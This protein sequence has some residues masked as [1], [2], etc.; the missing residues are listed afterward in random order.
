MEVK[1]ATK[2]EKSFQVGLGLPFLLIVLVLVVLVRLLLVLLQVLHFLLSFF[3][4][5]FLLFYV[6]VSFYLGSQSMLRY[7]QFSQKTQ[8]SVFVSLCPRQSE[9]A[10]AKN[11]RKAKLQSYAN[12]FR[13]SHT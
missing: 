9:R 7:S 12:P 3:F 4:V 8:A 2:R 6:S 13:V 5:F 1:N 11:A 10:A